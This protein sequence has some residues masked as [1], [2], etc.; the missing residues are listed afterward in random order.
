MIAE[1]KEW[2]RAR[3]RRRL[4]KQMDE[5]WAEW[6]MAHNVPFDDRNKCVRLGGDSG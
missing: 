5:F 4:I 3:R 6:A 2:W 1:L